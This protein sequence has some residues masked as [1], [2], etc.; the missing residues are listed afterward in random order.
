MTLVLLDRPP[1]LA[2]SVVQLEKEQDNEGFAAVT[3]AVGA[4]C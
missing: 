2:A 1:L 3:I 4:R